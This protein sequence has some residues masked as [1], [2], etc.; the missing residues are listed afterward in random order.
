MY[1]GWMG[2]VLVMRM[3]VYYCF[4]I[5]VFRFRD[6]MFPPSV[7]H[8]LS[9]H[10]HLNYLVIVSPPFIPTAS[11]A[12]ATVRNFVARS[13]NPNEAR[14]VFWDICTGSQRN[15]V[16]MGPYL[17]FIQCRKGACRYN[18]RPHHCSLRVSLCSSR[19]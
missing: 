13:A 18:S 2:G 15:H 17:C 11:A 12:S 8:K 4:H 10:T 16:S 7:G 1:A 3:K 5:I 6:L 14:G 19:V 9:V